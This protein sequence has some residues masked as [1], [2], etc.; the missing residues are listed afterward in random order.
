MPVLTV[1]LVTLFAC[2]FAAMAVAL[3]RAA[4]QGD[5]AIDWQEP[6]F[7][8]A[9]APASPAGTL[10][11]EVDLAGGSEVTTAIDAAASTRTA[12]TAITA[13]SP[14]GPKGKS[15]LRIPRASES[16]TAH[17]TSSPPAT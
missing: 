10:A 8:A 13:R 3:A 2:G 17:T 7:L 11:D 4:A 1:V 15:G 12:V 14:A 6:Y 16:T 9:A 5:R